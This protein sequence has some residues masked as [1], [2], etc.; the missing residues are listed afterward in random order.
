[1]FKYIAQFF[2]F[3][4]FIIFVISSI[5]LFITIMILKIKEPKKAY[6]RY[7]W[8]I[9]IL[10]SVLLFLSASASIN[11]SYSSFM[12]GFGGPSYRGMVISAVVLFVSSVFTF[13]LNYF[14]IFR[15]NIKKHRI[16]L[17]LSSS[18]SIIILNY[19]YGIIYN[20]IF[21]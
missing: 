13:I 9:V 7:I 17:S 20:L 8:Q 2:I 3:P 6:L 5:V 1:M 10:I 14:I 15:N 4:V 19:S 16:I 11:L 18:I 21:K 12:G